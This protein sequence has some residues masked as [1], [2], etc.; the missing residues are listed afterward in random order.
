MIAP[1]SHG[2]SARLLELETPSA[3]EF[4]D[5]LRDFCS[6]GFDSLKSLFQIIGLQNNQWAFK[7]ALPKTS[8][9]TSVL[10]TPTV[11]SI[12]DKAPP[13]CLAEKGLRC[14]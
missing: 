12:L 4:E 2:L 14:C 7:R 10:N 5:I 6:C 9:Q 13:R 1:H 11:F 3:G 8:A